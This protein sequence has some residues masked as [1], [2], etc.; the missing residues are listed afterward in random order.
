MDSN[1][2]EIVGKGGEGA[3]SPAEV[4]EKCETV[5]TML[6]NNDIVRAVYEVKSTFIPVKLTFYS[7]PFHPDNILFC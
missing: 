1:L 4:A 6:P 5:V 2:A 3:G 7:I